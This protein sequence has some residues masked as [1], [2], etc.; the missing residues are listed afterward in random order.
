VLEVR[1]LSVDFWVDGA[2]VPAV[3]GLDYEVAPG[4]V[5]ALVGESGS[6]KTTG[7][8]ALLGLLPA[9]SRTSGSVRLAG[10][11]LLGSPR[12]LRAARGK[13]IAMVFQE[14]AT[15]L[16]P[17]QTAGAQ[18]VEA[19][20]L[21]TPA[22]PRAAEERALGLL[23]LVGLPDAATAFRSYPH[24]LSGGQQQRVLIAQALACDP[25]LLVADEPTAALDV[26][27]QAEILALLR[28]LRDD[29]G[30]AI[31]L[32]T[33]DMGVVA[34]LADR[35]A[36]LRAGRLVETGP[37]TQVFR[38]PEH[39]YTRALLA[40]VP[41]LGEAGERTGDDAGA[42]AARTAG[43]DAP[44]GA[45]VLELRDVAVDYPRR[46]RVPAVR[47]VDGVSLTVRAGQVVGL[48]GESGSGKTTLARASAGLLGIAAGSL[49]ILGRDASAARRNPRDLRELRRSVG[50]VFQDP[51]SSLN[52]RLPVG[53]SIAEPLLLA[54]RGRRPE[55]EA[56]V[57]ALL[58]EVGLPRSYRNRYPHELSGGQRQRVGIARA[59]ALRPRLLV[60][61]EP[62][63]ALDVSV[64][65]AILGLLQTLQREHG[66]ACL[67]VTHDLAVADA[68]ADHICVM[69]RGRI[70]EQGPREAVLRSPA[71]DY[72]RQLL[73][74]VPVPDPTRQRRRRE[75]RGLLAEAAQGDS[76][77]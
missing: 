36:V 34:D 14:P 52:P 32:I 9:T 45:A 8:M 42:T 55:R 49:S 7:S 24:Q 35:V 67:F 64:Q 61:D 77:K 62:T 25:A 70:V 65:T 21:H 17:V 76:L 2:W 41:R 12:R 3:S 5:L 56:R 33:H 20:R 18:I 11:E 6:G 23:R 48:V 13:G 59:L 75:L 30:T 15:A 53:E 47:A 50:M 66:F 69:R 44:G 31:L 40:A 57:S 37:V 16:N 71:T 63:S 51:S 29:L 39:P 1:G 38:T 54:G 73:A 4:E 26:T 22:S 60:A 43:A 27:V 19:I 58:E 46:G 74:A 72:A 68:V 10:E 28:R